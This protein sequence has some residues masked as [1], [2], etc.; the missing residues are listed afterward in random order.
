[1]NVLV[2]SPHPD[3]AELYAGGFIAKLAR[4]GAQVSIAIVTD[5]SKGSFEHDPPALIPIRE[6]EARQASIA[7][8]AN[9]PI[10]LGYPDTEMDSLPSGKLR[11]QF[12]RLVRENKPALTI[13]EDPFAPYTSHPD[14]RAVAAA[15]SDAIHLAA[16]PLV[17]PEHLREGLETHY[18]VDKYYY[19]DRLPEPPVFHE[20]ARTGLY[21]AGRTGFRNLV[22]D[23]EG[24]I[25]VKVA[26]IL[27]HR[28]QVSFLFEDVLRQIRLAGLEPEEATRGIGADPASALTS[29]VL[30][31]AGEVGRLADL[32]YGEAF[33]YER[34]H[35][36]VETLLANPDIR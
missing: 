21:P 12:I 17:H 14:H 19:S 18:V 2:F 6:E 24:T 31:Q 1:M 20:T 23:I 36:A 28:S 7:L 32:R 13:A 22:V 35:P 15:A 16:L 25:D 8:G 30:T 34:F 29:F 5:G 9:P 26:A 11:E 27:E 10:F 33:R 4:Q 3:D